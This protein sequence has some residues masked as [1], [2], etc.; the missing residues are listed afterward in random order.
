MGRNQQS[1]GGGY[2][3]NQ[4]NPYAS[5][6][7]GGNN[8]KTASDA[9]ALGLGPLPQQNTMLS[10]LAGLGI[11]QQNPLDSLFGSVG[12]NTLAGLGGLNTG[13]QSAN[14]EKDLRQLAALLGGSQQQSASSSF[15]ES[16]SERVASFITQH[17]GARGCSSPEIRKVRQSPC[18]SA[19][20]DKSAG[21]DMRSGSNP[22]K[23]KLKTMSFADALPSPTP[24]EQK[25]RERV[26]ARKRRH[27]KDPDSVPEE[28]NGGKKEEFIIRPAFVVKCEFS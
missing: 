11:A 1:K 4:G 17:A 3:G 15:S 20:S 25:A 7:K 5:G 18:L 24:E 13:L 26:E 10:G 2:A 19:K 22:P 12:T 14:G 23:H 6:G 8:K 16:V 28:G 9:T 27:K 21:S